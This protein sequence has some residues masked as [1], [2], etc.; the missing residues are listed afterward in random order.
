MH[1]QWRHSSVQQHYAVLHTKSDYSAQ[2]SYLDKLSFQGTL[3][4]NSALFWISFKDLVSTK[5]EIHL[6]FNTFVYF[7][8]LMWITRVWSTQ[9][10][11]SIQ[12]DEKHQRTH[13]WLCG[14]CGRC[15]LCCRVAVDGHKHPTCSNIWAGWCW[16]WHFI[17]S[18]IGEETCAA[19]AIRLFFP[20]QCALYQNDGELHLYVM[21]CI[22]YH[23]LCCIHYL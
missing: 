20:H 18:Y 12:C 4:F 15:A 21:S 1:V 9:C 2:F 11:I 13:H 17:G 3:N 14:S 10:K 19:C 22:I 8:D 16:P 6:L 23:L 5:A 7:Q